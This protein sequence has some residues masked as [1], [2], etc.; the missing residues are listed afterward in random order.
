MWIP[1]GKA[2]GKKFLKLENLWGFLLSTRRVF[3]KET[4]HQFVKENEASEGLSL[5]GKGIKGNDLQSPDFKSDEDDFMQ[6]MNDTISDQGSEMSALLVFKSNQGDR[7]VDNTVKLVWCF[8]WEKREGVRFCAK[9]FLDKVTRLN[10]SPRER[11]YTGGL[12]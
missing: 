5:E 3:F 7:M 6:L 8:S 1:I 10:R 2:G 4:A 11:H 12:M 9:E